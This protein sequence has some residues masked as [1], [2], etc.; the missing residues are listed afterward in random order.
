MSKGAKIQA[1]VSASKTN[2]G[3]VNSEAQRAVHVACDARVYR[4][5]P[6]ACATEVCTDSPTPPNNSTNTRIG[7]YTAP[8]AEVAAG[9]SRPM[10]QVS[11]AFNT[12]CTPLFS[13]NGKARTATA[14]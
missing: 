13:M 14:R 11:V 6:N 12:A 7:Q 1:P 9:D 10:N 3:T 4:R 5:P 8:M 2:K